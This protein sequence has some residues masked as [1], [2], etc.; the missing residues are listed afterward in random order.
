MA[1][2]TDGASNMN[3]FGRTIE[4]WRAKHLMHHYCVDHV[5][6]LTAIIA[7]SVNDSL[8]IYDEDTSVG[9]LTDEGSTFSVTYQFFM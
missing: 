8:D 4:S 6:Q 5:F 2:V 3:D 1:A 7:F 9:C